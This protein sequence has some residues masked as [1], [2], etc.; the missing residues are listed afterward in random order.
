MPVINELQN[1]QNLFVD[2]DTSKALC[3]ICRADLYTLQT[4]KKS[5][6]VQ[7]VQTEFSI[8]SNTGRSQI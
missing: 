7:T 5:E 6:K 8:N 4:R 1:K 3:I 2:L